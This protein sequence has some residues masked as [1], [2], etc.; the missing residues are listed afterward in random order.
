MTAAALQRFVAAVLIATCILLLSAFALTSIR[1]SEAAKAAIVID[2]AQ[3]V[4]DGERVDVALPVRWR[5]SWGGTR[6]RVFDIT[7]PNPPG[8]WPV[9]L[10]VPY[11]EQRLTVSVEGDEIFRSEHVRPW[12][13]SFAQATALVLIPRDRLSVEGTRVRLTIGSG[14]NPPGG[15]SPI[16]VGGAE[17]LSRVYLLRTFIEDTAKPILFGMQAFVALMA[18]LVFAQRPK[19]AV[20]GWMGLMLTL[21]TIASSSVLVRAVPGVFSS[22]EAVFLVIPAAGLAIVGFTMALAGRQ[23]PRTLLYAVPGIILAMV[24]LRY[25]IGLGADKVGFFVSVPIFVLCALVGAVF[26]WHTIWREPRPETILFALGLLLLVGAVIRDAGIR[27]GLLETGIFLGQIS[28]IVVLMAIAIFIVRR[29]SDIANRLDSAA[30]DLQ[31][32][33]TEREAQLH[34][35]HER[36]RAQESARLIEDERARMTADLHDGVAGHLT[37]I[38]ALSEASTSNVDQIR[39]SARNALVDLRLVLDA[40]SVPDGDLLFYLAQFRERCIEPL[41]PLG[42]DVTWSMTALP[43]APDFGREKAL[44]LLRILQE[45]VNNTLKHTKLEAL[46]LVAS[47]PK[48]GFARITISN[49]GALTQSADRGGIGLESIETRARALGGVSRFEQRSDGAELTIEFPV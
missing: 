46:S 42:V 23:V 24:V 3:Q 20:F 33:L 2:S 32:K 6:S 28:R 21:A 8:D 49:S 37:T 13:G 36:Q 18:L 4:I 39:D 12:A 1:A 19:D 17:A 22:M 48:S 47:S 31:A 11:F 14:P 25:G 29:Q 7:L 15:L 35:L 26:L 38:V 30:E 5:D 27:L 44:L 41:V 34:A 9:Y 10:H 43:D 40:L 45:A 16:Y